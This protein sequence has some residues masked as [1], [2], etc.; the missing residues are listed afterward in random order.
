MSKNKNR[1]V[2]PNAN[3]IYPVGHTAGGWVVIETFPSKNGY[4]G[5]LIEATDGSGKKRKRDQKQIWQL[6]GSRERRDP[7]VFRDNRLVELE[8][9]K[10]LTNKEFGNIEHKFLGNSRQH[11]FRVCTPEGKFTRWYR[12]ND[13]S[14]LLKGEL[15]Y[16]LS[17]KRAIIV[18]VKARLKNQYERDLHYLKNFDS[19]LKPWLWE[20]GRPVDVLESIIKPGKSFIGAMYKIEIKI[21]P[22]I[23]MWCEK[24]FPLVFVEDGLKYYFGSFLMANC[25]SVTK[26]Q[27]YGGAGMGGNSIYG[28]L[29]RVFPDN[30]DRFIVKMFY[31]T[32]KEQV[33]SEEYDLIKQH[34]GKSYC[35][36]I[37]A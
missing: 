28:E 13:I 32:T 7:M 29:M 24:N 11:A 25:N 21:T 31:G 30:V 35:L 10:K 22:E 5:Y 26:F 27:N 12:F 23:R 37:L 18:K 3:Q 34:L 33:K 1:Q 17:K 20:D 15:S 9:L 16:K 36:N 4:P 2:W 6:R 8:A 19:G 14:R